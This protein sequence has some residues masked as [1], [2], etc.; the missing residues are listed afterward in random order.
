MKVLKIYAILGLFVLFGCAS[1]TKMMAPSGKQGYLIK[2][3]S[4]M[5]VCYEKAAE[6][7]P[8]GYA[9]A[10]KDKSVSGYNG[11]VDTINSMMIECK[12]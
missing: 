1:S 7:C 3:Y 2:C 12:K 9:I 6:T 5:A 10:N 8:N 4:D 11:T